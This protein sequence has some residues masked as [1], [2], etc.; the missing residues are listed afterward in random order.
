ML[1]VNYSDGACGQRWILSGRL[2]GPWVEELRSFWLKIR[3]RSPLAPATVDLRDVTFVDEAGKAL[4]AEMHH[5]G[6]D[7]IARG[8]ENQYLLAT[9]APRDEAPARRRARV[10]SKRPT[11]V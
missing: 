9:L 11:I 5:S 10:C 2:A 3:E 7:F 6:A 1:R 4:L 8:V